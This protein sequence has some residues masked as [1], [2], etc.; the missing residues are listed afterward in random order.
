[1]WLWCQ[2][3]GFFMLSRL[4]KNSRKSERFY[5]FYTHGGAC[6]WGCRRQP[7][8]LP[9]YFS[10]GHLDVHEYKFLEPLGKWIKRSRLLENEVR[11]LR[12]DVAHNSG[13]R[14]S[15]P[16]STSEFLTMPA[17][18]SISCFNVTTKIDETLRA[19]RVSSGNDVRVYGTE[20]D[21]DFEERRP[22]LDCALIF[23]LF[24]CVECCVHYV[25]DPKKRL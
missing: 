13:N 14:K 15:K 1:M 2:N 20:I 24:L 22:F 10:G 8:A 16:K 23:P 5:Y 25:C 18:V 21:R 17:K 6:A 12:N 19:S 11:D 9:P 7:R 4:Q 3:K